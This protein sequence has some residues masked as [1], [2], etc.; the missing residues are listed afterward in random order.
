MSLSRGQLADVAADRPLGLYVHVPFC[1]RRCLYCD[2][3]SNV[4]AAEL[5]RPFVDAVLAELAFWAGRLDLSSLRTIFIGGGTPTVL[6]PDELARLIDAIAASPANEFTIEA[7]PA[8][9]SPSLADRLRSLGVNRI[10]FGAQSFDPAELA[11]LG[12]AHSVEQI[13]DSVRIARRAGYDNVNLDVMYGLPGQSLAGWRSTL[14]AAVALG[15]EHLSC[16]A[17]SYEPGTELARRAKAGLVAPVPDEA[18]VAMY[19]AAQADL[20]AAGFEHYE[21]SN[22]AKPGRQCRHNLLYWQNRPWLGLGPSAASF[23]AGLRFK[24]R[25]SLADYEAAAIA[26]QPEFDDI[27]H[28]TGLPAVGE[29]MMLALRLRAGLDADEFARRYGLDIR[30][31]FA[32]VIARHEQAGLLR[33]Q[34]SR[35]QLT[36]AALPVS[37]SVLVDFIA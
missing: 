3:N 31:Q 7:N 23:L 17:L 4:F 18:A 37:D 35:L 15:V 36:E 28:L 1:L 5:A 34:G 25:A 27:E 8:T 12:R 21:I 16:Y 2:F 11:L 10:S 6:P 32:E 14:A 33:W 29:A 22:W 30:R 9:V 13:A 24:G 26:G 19:A 20:A